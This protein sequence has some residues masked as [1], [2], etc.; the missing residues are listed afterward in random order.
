MAR[1]L[2]DATSPRVAS[3]FINADLTPTE[4]KLAFEERERRRAR[5]IARSLPI[6]PPSVSAMDVVQD[7]GPAAD[8]GSSAAAG[9]GTGA[10]GGAS[11]VGGTH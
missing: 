11:A 1:S 3:V 5:N 10:D 8:A 2:R 7:T 9:A 4:A 6:P